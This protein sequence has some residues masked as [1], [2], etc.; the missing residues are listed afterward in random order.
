MATIDEEVIELESIKTEIDILSYFKNNFI[1]D[2]FIIVAKEN[3]IND[4]ISIASL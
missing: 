1:I 4:L 2:K 3:K